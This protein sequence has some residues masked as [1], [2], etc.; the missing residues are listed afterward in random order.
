MEHQ[1]LRKFLEECVIHSDSA[2]LLFMKE[3]YF[4]K[5][6]KLKA[7]H[8]PAEW[9]RAPTQLQ[10]RAN[11]RKYKLADHIQTHKLLGINLK[12]GSRFNFNRPFAARCT[13]L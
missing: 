5:P 11:H 2:D 8:L 3:Y 6:L 1:M 12:K 7:T 10:R 4:Q 9:S 13:N